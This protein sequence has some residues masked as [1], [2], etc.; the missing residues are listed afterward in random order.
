M[1]RA[2]HVI[3]CSVA[4]ALI[5]SLG[6]A[7][8]RATWGVS[9]VWPANGL[10]VGL[11]YKGR[12]TQWCHIAL[13]VFIGGVLS[14][15]WLRSDAFSTLIFSLGNV[16][17][18]S[19]AA[20]VLGR[21]HAP[22]TAMPHPRG[23]FRFLVLA[24]LLPAGMSALL[25]GLL[26]HA[27]LDWP[28]RTLAMTWLS[29]DALGLAIF[30]PLGFHVRQAFRNA[31]RRLRAKGAHRTLLGRLAVG[32]AAHLIILLVSELIFNPAHYVAPFWALPPIVLSVLW[33]GSYA[34]VTGT[35][36][37]AAV[38]VV[39]TVSQP[40]NSAFGKVLQ[41]AQAIIEVQGFALACLLTTYLM[42]AILSDRQRY[43][44]HTARS[45]C[46]QTR[47]ADRLRVANE[48][49]NALAHRDP[50]TGVANRREFDAS[51]AKAIKETSTSDRELGLI[52]IDVDWFKKYNDC[53]GHQKGDEALCA[54]AD[55]LQMNLPQGTTV[56]R[57]GGEEFA[58]IWPDVHRDTLV[59]CAR[60]AVS[61]VS[62][63]GIPHGGSSHGR[64][65][66]SV[67]AIALQPS[68]TTLPAE[69]LV[70]ADAAMYRAKQEGRNRYALASG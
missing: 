64:V 50:L 13:A 25:V 51:L 8:T 58:I 42:A 49:L 5:A 26:A 22:V 28:M 69:L 7:L 57:I 35:F 63:L 70:K 37:T 54:V 15:L 44:R 4:F 67:G 29:S 21:Q 41:P 66:V 20:V 48:E 53:Y 62:V 38:A 12:K 10:I 65:T 40:L 18:V 59:H 30:L 46:A 31:A 11:L 45:H 3:V 14:N 24:A 36:L 2:L 23:L 61:R 52:F 17:E 33:A 32:A 19:S 47:L 9:S 56:A 55:A 6:I 60:Q 27:I 16:A 1:N 68:P 34:A 39:S 43:L